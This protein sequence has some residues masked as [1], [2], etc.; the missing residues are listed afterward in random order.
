RS[1]EDAA[2]L[3]ETARA[4]A[5]RAGLTKVVLWEEPATAALL[6][7]LPGATRVARDGSLPMLRPLRPGL[8]PAASI[9][10]PR[11]LWV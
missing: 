2:V 9:P 5:H 3:V 7:R 4:V 11:A 10:F 8:P 6:A 1:D